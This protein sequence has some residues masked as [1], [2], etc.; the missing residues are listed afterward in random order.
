MHLCL[1]K[2][3]VQPPFQLKPR[4]YNP[5]A[6]HYPAVGPEPP[7]GC[8]HHR[9][10]P[11]PARYPNQ[12]TATPFSVRRRRHTS[13]CQNCT[14]HDWT[15][16]QCHGDGR[17][18]GKVPAPSTH[19]LYAQTCLLF[20]SSVLD[21]VVGVSRTACGFRRHKASLS[22]GFDMRSTSFSFRHCMLRLTVME[23]G[24]GPYSCTSHTVYSNTAHRKHHEHSKMRW[25]Y[26]SEPVSHARGCYPTC[27]T[28]GTCAQCLAATVAGAFAT[29]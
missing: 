14:L 15:V 23:Y 29:A 13:G 27:R 4:R 24:T 26:S 25:N 11:P 5:S 20:S 10:R 21:T 7:E 2:P 6:D 19:D 1:S 12:R 3:G 18:Q 28:R 16:D 22:L 8:Q 17:Q 9:A